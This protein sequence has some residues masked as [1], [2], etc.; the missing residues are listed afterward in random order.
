[1]KITQGQ[2]FEI[3]D[4]FIKKCK[5]VETEFIDE[6][7][8][9]FIDGIEAKINDDTSFESALMQTSDD[10]GGV[11]LL[12][13]MEWNFQKSAFQKQ[14]K[15]WINTVRS[16]FSTPKLYRSVMIFALVFVIAFWIEPNGS[17][18]F[19]NGLPGFIYGFLTLPSFVLLGFLLQRHSSFIRSMGP[20]KIKNLINGIIPGSAMLIS[21]F[22][23]VII[24]EFVPQGIAKTILYSIQISVSIIVFIASFLHFNKEE[25]ENWYRPS[26]R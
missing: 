3:E 23:F 13:K 1:M 20:V 16:Y 11:P 10:F 17:S 4:F 8:D 12:R 7:M 5:L 25:L 19:K 6:M 22:L 9:H 14:I 18:T 24:G 26:S 21:I 2:Y 15:A